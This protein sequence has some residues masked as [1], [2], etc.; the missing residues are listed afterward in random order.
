LE[1]FL[2]ILLAGFALLFLFV[3]KDYGA[4]AALFPRVVAIFSLVL[5]TLDIFW[6]YFFMRAKGAKPQAEKNEISQT[7]SWQSA[8]ALQAGYIGLIYVA[9]FSVATLA[10]LIA[11]PWQLRYRNWLVTI[12]HAVLLMVAIVYTFHTVFHVRLPKGVLGIPW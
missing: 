7:V 2:Q 3:T 9:G 11:C 8:L 4:T 6:R 12:V 10:Y 1:A 5:I